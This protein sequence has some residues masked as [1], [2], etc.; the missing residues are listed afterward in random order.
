MATT[1]Q[2]VRSRAGAWVGRAFRMAFGLVAVGVATGFVAVRVS[3]ARAAEAG[4]NFGD[5]LR[6]L[7]EGRLTGALSSEVYELS[8]NGQPFD[9]NS[10]ATRR[11]MKEVLDY[12][13]EQCTNNASGLSEELGHLSSTLRSLPAGKGVPGYLTVRKEAGDRSFVFCMAPDHELTAKEKLFRLRD[14]SDF[15]NFGRLGDVRY[16]SVMQEAGGSTVTSMWTHGDFNV[17]TM[18]PKVGDSPGEDLGGV[19]RPDGARRVLTGHIVGAPY[20]VN[21][22]E[23][24]GLPAVALSAVDA[25][26]QGMGWK[27]VSIPDEI[28]SRS[29]FYSH[30]NAMD[31]QVIA[32]QGSGSATNVAYM[33]SRAIGT[34]TR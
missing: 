26:L 31:I 11:P 9:T 30:G 25:K 34:V 27:P 2:L 20:G 24:Q 18:F 4:L 14:V 33:V 5:E 10:T 7:G 6:Q 19:P 23:V 21:V 32:Q 28:H 29:R 12:F 22:Y 17:N 15:G 16:I 13:Q 1:A 3:Y 8:L